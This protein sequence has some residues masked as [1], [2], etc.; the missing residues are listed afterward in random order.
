MLDYLAYQTAQ[1][2]VAEL[3]RGALS[4][5]PV[6]LPDEASHPACPHAS[7]SLRATTGALL[8]GLADHLNRGRLFA[9]SPRSTVAE[10]APVGPPCR[11]SPIPDRA[12]EPRPMT[13]REAMGRRSALELVDV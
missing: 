9:P 12:V 2:R 4:D 5:S 1:R 13:D 3:A 7:T 10:A 11:H 6:R 8:R